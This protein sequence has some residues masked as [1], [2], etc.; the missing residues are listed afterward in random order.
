MGPT[1]WEQY[2]ASPT[3]TSE[4]AQGVSPGTSS[5]E[6]AVAHFYA[7]RIRGDEAWQ[8][9]LPEEDQRSDTLRR[10]LERM[11][12]WHYTSM[13]LVTRKPKSQQRFYVRVALELEIAG[14]H[15]AVQN[16][17]TVQLI[18]DRWLVMRPPT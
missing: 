10:K 16:E 8:E 1:R 17:V 2:Q 9:V 11:A 4:N 3:I 5:P 6:A 7:S 18:G 14:R 13:A 15:Q 12:D